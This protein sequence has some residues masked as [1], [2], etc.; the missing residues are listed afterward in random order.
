MIFDF[1]IFD[2]NFLI[3]VYIGL[4]PVFA[5]L[6]VIR[7]YADRIK[8]WWWLYK[9]PESVYL[10]RFHY[11][12]RM[13][14]EH[15]VSTG[16]EE[17]SFKDGTYVIKK[18]AIIRK[19]WT[20]IIPNNEVGINKDNYIGWEDYKIYT[21]SETRERPSKACLVGE[22]EYIFGV[23]NPI[24]FKSA[25]E[26]GK[27]QEALFEINATEVKRIQKNSV[28]DQLLTAEFKKNALI[29]IM[30]L[31]VVSVIIGGVLLAV[32]LEWLEVPL[33]V[34]CLNVG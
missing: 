3:W 27:D 11:P 10:V 5:G 19:N 33:H 7:I 22:L 17:F 12:N 9:H 18:R 14:S 32:R 16:Y 26:K 29:F 31:V 15:Y 34:V 6:M 4:T 1:L 20:G 13:Y 8:Q 23:P 21:E 25:V 30:L 2:V 24:E 28:L